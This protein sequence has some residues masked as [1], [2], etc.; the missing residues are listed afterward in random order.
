MQC[1]FILILIAGY[2]TFSYRT[3]PLALSM[4]ESL[5]GVAWSHISSI[6]SVTMVARLCS[7]SVSYSIL[8]HGLYH[9]EHDMLTDICKKRIVVAEYARE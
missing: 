1:L 8:I 4:S 9:W 6:L 2:P 5:T 7:I 3:C